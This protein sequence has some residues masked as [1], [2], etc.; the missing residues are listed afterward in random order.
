MV[1]SA[2][3]L[4]WN[5][6]GNWQG[7]PKAFPPSVKIS[8]ET[9]YE[10]I[11]VFLL[12]VWQHGKTVYFPAQSKLNGYSGRSNSPPS[13]CL[14]TSGDRQEYLSGQ[15]ILSLQSPPPAYRWGWNNQSAPRQTLL[16]LILATVFHPF[17]SCRRT[18]KFQSKFHSFIH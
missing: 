9:Q 7:A 11:W 13:V 16:S 8:E 3:H 10:R 2:Y 17:G 4:F 15:N 6:N 14:L 1:H 12:F 5:L 18:L